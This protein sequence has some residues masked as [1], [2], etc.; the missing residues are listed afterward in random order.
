MP[1]ACTL[2]GH[3]PRFEAQGTT[4]QWRCARG[5]GAHASRTYASA[6]EAARYARALDREDRE[7]L[8]R[9]PLLSLMALKLARHAGGS[10]PGSSR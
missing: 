4:L 9:R 1:L 6:Q 7:D 2:L 3:R 5:C 10:R 8:G